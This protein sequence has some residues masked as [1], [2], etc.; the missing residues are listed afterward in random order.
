MHK[1]TR[2]IYALKTILKSVISEYRME[3]QLQ[4]EFD[5][6]ASLDHPSIIRSYVKFEDEFHHFILMEYFHGEELLSRLKS[7]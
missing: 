6:Q 5:I 2:T 4:Q 7:P 1:R 3:A